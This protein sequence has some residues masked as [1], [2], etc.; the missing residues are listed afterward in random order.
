M[1][2]VP[3]ST[4]R[5]LKRMYFFNIVYT[6]FR[7][8]DHTPGLDTLPLP[9]ALSFA[10]HPDALDVGVPDP[11][12]WGWPEMLVRPHWQLLAA[13]EVVPWDEKEDKAYWRGQMS[14]GDEVRVNR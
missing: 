7:W 2:F 13:K 14:K 9:F 1:H 6:Q 11:T 4:Q 3:L 12:Y 8:P 5:A 10:R